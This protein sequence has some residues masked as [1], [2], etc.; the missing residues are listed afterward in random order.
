MRRMSCVLALSVCTIL[1]GQT[2][3][4]ITSIPTE[5]GQISGLSDTGL[6]TG[7]SYD[8]SINYFSGTIWNSTNNS[9]GDLGAYMPS[10]ISGN[11]KIA[12]VVETGSGRHLFVSDEL[13]HPFDTG[14]TARYVVGI[15][16]TG[17]VLYYNY[18]NNTYS[19][20]IYDSVTGSTQSI[21]SF[22]P[23]GINN[24]GEL[25]GGDRF[26]SLQNGPQMISTT[27][28][29]WANALN[30]SGTVV[31]TW[32]G[33]DLSPSS[34][35]YKAFT[36]S[37]SQGFTNI[38]TL[39]DNCSAMGIN[40]M[41]T[42]VGRSEMPNYDMHAWIYNSD[43]GMLDLNRFLLNANGW[44][45]L[46]EAY[47]INENGQILGW[48]TKNDGS[49]GYFLLTPVPEPATMLLF[50]IGGLLYKKYNNLT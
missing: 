39:G 33:C 11:G 35:P 10:C 2:K 44:Q 23:Y 15:N 43:T 14:I 21:P 31:G 30:D 7:F 42:I 1:Y 48:G 19:N 24:N 3:Y 6:V 41:G 36:W 22:Q 49:C 13:G 27:V 37:Q 50:G 5:M 20:Y 25:A 45:C 16:N 4:T 46:N 28:L 26:W 38:G 47:Y 12:G 29:V 34:F 18:P 32:R 8:Y 9:F 17:Q 40:N